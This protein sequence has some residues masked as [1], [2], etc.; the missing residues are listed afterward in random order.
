MFIFKYV[1]QLLLFICQNKIQIYFPS[2][3]LP[4]VF[5]LLS[6][7]II[8]QMKKKYLFDSLY[9]WVLYFNSRLIFLY[10]NDNTVLFLLLC[11]YEDI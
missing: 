8:S 5:E 6:K 4:T 11:L 1:I 9:F 7:T 2:G 10:S 3:R